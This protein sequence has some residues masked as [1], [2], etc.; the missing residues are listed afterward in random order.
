MANKQ[1]KRDRREA[2]RRAASRRQRSKLVSLVAVIVLAIGAFVVLSGGSGNQVAAL[3][4]KF[5]LETNT[6][7]TVSLSD[8]RGQPVALTFMHTY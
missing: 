5:D 8:Y 7:E 2:A 6:G 3:A 1:S 4:P